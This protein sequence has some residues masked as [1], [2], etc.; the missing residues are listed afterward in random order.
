MGSAADRA[1]TAT[2]DGPGARRRVAMTAALVLLVLAAGLGFIGR[3]VGLLPRGADRDPTRLTTALART[4]ETAGIEA[5]AAQYRTLRAQRFGG[6]RESEGDT[7]RLGYALLRQGQTA[8]AIQVFQLNTETHSA[9]ANVWDRLGEAYVIAGN[10]QLA[11]ASY[12]KALTIDPKMKTARSERCRIS[13]VASGRPIDR[14]S[15]STF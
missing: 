8:N 3:V 10:R 12:E 13:R 14:W 9:S 7:N 4:I 15:S 5:A 1:V 6:L 2:T 11:I